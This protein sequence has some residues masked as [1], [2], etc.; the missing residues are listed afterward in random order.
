MIAALYKVSYKYTSPALPIYLVDFKTLFSSIAEFRG[1]NIYLKNFSFMI[2][3]INF[4]GIFYFFLKKEEVV[5]GG[6]F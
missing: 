2:Y 3:F 4:H 5:W 6:G 1:K